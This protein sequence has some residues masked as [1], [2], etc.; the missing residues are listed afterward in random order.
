M[1]EYSEAFKA[2]MIKKMTG[3]RGRSAATLAK[4]VGVH[5]TTLSRWLRQAGIVAGMS[6]SKR[7]SDPAPPAAKRT[8]DWTPAEKLQVVAEE[9]AHVQLDGPGSNLVFNRFGGVGACVSSAGEVHC[10]GT[11]TYGHL[12]P[13]NPPEPEDEWKPITVSTPTPQGL[14]AAGTTALGSRHLCAVFDGG[15]VRC[16]GLNAPL[17]MGYETAHPS[18]VTDPVRTEGGALYLCNESP[19][20]CLGDDEPWSAIP[21]LDV[22]GAVR[23]IT[24]GN[25]DIEFRTTTTCVLMEGGEVR[26]WGDGADGQLGVPGVTAAATPANARPV[27][28]GMAA[29]D[30]QAGRRFVCALGAAGRVRCWG[31]NERGQLGYSHREN[32]GDDE[33]PTNTAHVL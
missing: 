31:N 11:S 26:C 5:Q 32:I 28:L 7:N 18:C 1:T 22:G 17:T 16:R 19:V 8:Q 25:A 30:V 14:R 4:E 6:G 20:C 15:S 9:A 29:V 10:W 13:A 23:D 24:I 3:P 27:D 12:N 33:T 21:D 2:T